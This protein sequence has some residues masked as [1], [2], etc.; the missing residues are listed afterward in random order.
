MT[1]PA[2]Y[3]IV[4]LSILS[5]ETCAETH[6]PP[7]CAS[8]HCPPAKVS[9]KESIVRKPS[10][11][12]L[13]GNQEQ[14]VERKRVSAQLDSPYLFENRKYGAEDRSRTP[15]DCKFGQH[16]VGD[17]EWV[18]CRDEHEHL[19]KNCTSDDDCRPYPGQFGICV[20]TV[21][22]TRRCATLCSRNHSCPAGF[23]CLHL[24]NLELC[25]PDTGAWPAQSRHDAA[26]TELQ[27]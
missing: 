10:R 16:I 27:P 9:V 7:V 12:I 25:F 22:A 13:D 18:E 15:I 8:A 4:L 21:G 23:E 3:L 19:A 11:P 24:E 6:Q 5:C 20:P 2:L 17:D 14:L 26:E 1:H